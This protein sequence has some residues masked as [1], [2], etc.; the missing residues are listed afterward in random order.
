[1]K[2]SYNVG[3]VTDDIKFNKEI[4]N[5]S[6]IPTE[7]KPYGSMLN[8]AGRKAYFEEY[9]N[10]VK[11]ENQEIGSIGPFTDPRTTFSFK[12]G[13]K[14]GEFLV[15]VGIVPEKYTVEENNNKTR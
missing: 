15:K 11:V 4:K 1:M 13:Y 6:V 7:E 14:R 9:F 12:T 2:E 8:E 5:A 10:G 3:K